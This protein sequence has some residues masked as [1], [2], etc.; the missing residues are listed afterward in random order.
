MHGESSI[1]YDVVCGR[2]VRSFDSLYAAESAARAFAA[3]IG[4]TARVERR[5]ETITWGEVLQEF[6]A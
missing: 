6:A 3:E 1:R 5:I 4:E 2:R